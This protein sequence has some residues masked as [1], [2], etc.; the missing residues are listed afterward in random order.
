M[1]RS[2]AADGG[3]MRK[4]RRA[5]AEKRAMCTAL[6]FETRRCR[7]FSPL[8]LICTVINFLFCFTGS[9]RSRSRVFASAPVKQ[10]RQT[11]LSA[12]KEKKKE[13]F[14]RLAF[15]IVPFCFFPRRFQIVAALPRRERGGVT[16]IAGSILAIDAARYN[17]IL[18]ITFVRSSINLCFLAS[19]APRVSVRDG[20]VIA[21]M[22]LVGC[23]RY[24]AW[25]TWKPVLA[26]VL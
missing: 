9:L 13:K 4:T 18:E 15:K 25:S 1:P 19:P 11:C 10:Q 20:T 17:A 3:A 23:C 7:S 16:S 6:A 5:L 21:R 14:A 12:R 22:R 26:T 8:F 24:R 2:G